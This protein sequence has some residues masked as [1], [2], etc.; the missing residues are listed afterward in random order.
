MTAVHVVTNRFLEQPKNVFWSSRF[1]DCRV[2]KQYHV[3]AARNGELFVNTQYSDR[4]CGQIIYGDI[5]L[6]VN[7]IYHYDSIMKHTVA[8]RTLH[9]GD[10]C[11]I[12]I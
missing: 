4:R 5:D 3:L 7:I 2:K 6:Q 10:Q 11:Y 12:S 8:L 1:V 9:C